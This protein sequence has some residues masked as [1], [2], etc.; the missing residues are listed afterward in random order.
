MYT[1]ILYLC[2]KIKSNVSSVCASTIQL[3]VHV[4]GGVSSTIENSLQT[5]LRKQLHSNTFCVGAI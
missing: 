4:A 1:H 5:E 2:E 3:A